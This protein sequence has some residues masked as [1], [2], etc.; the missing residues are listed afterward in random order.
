[1]L[2]VKNKLIDN[3]TA[4]KFAHETDACADCY[5]NED[6]TIP[7]GDRRLVKLGFAMQLPNGYESVIRPRSE[8]LRKVLMLLSVLLI[9]VI[10]EKCLLM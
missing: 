3:G 5:A 7:I 2:S 10:L 1:M 4:P 9:M 8:T 6:V